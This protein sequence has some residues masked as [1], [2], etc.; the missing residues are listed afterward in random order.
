M[1]LKARRGALRIAVSV[2]VSAITVAVLYFGYQ[3]VSVG[4]AYTAHLLCSG[5]FVAGRAPQSI[6]D[7]D[8]AADDLAVLRH[9][10]TDVDVASRQVSAK[11][12]G[13][14]RRTAIYR[15]GLGCALVYAGDGNLPISTVVGPKQSAP[16]ARTEHDPWDDRE[17]MPRDFDRARLETALDWAFSEPDPAHLRRTRAVVIVHHGR[18]V[19]ERYADGFRTDTP[20]IGWSMTKSVINALVGILVE[21]GAISLDAPAPVRSWRAAGDRRRAITL[22]H[23]LRMSSGL[24]FDEDAGNPLADAMHMLLGVPDMAAYAAA[25][26]LDA[27]PGVRWSYSS[28]TTNIIAGVI[29][30]V[31]GESDYPEFPRRALFERIGMHS[32]VLE[33]DAAGTFVGSS[34]MYATARDW[35]RFGLLYLND[36]QWAGQRILPEGWVAYSRTSAPAAPHREYGAHFWLEVPEEYRRDPRPR[37]L[38]ADAFHAAGHEG[39]F[40]TIIPSRRLVVVRLGLTRYPS[41]WNHHAFLSQILDAVPALGQEPADKALRLTRH[42]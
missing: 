22:D 33:T 19:A 2:G 21:Q 5:V 41:A 24:R 3:L 11:A 35:A 37:G 29:R 14:A 7:A 10:S 28:G 18:L 12:F 30:Q 9:I 39:Q 31:V 13:L 4:T 26:P 32:A 34:F 25:K 15:E 1:S 6:L 16:E 8:L 20:L 38:P 23:L 27:A 36:G 40:V 17:T 42:H